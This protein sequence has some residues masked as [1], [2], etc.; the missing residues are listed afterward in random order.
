MTMQG[1]AEVSKTVS[2][3]TLNK[4]R[5]TH[6][7]RLLEGL[8]RGDRVKECVVVEMGGDK[9]AL[10]ET[11]FPARRVDL[12]HPGLPLAAAR[13]AGRRAAT[14]ELLVFLDVDC[15]PS[16]DLVN[17]L[18]EGAASRESLVCCAVT[19]LPDG[20]VRDGWTELDLR[21]VGSRHPAR[22]FPS[23]GLAQAPNPGLF[24]SL[25][26]AVQAKTYDRLDG[27]DEAYSGYGAED[28][29]LAFRADALGI[30]VL[31]SAHGHAYHQRHAAYD[32]P[33]QHFS[34]IISNARRFHDR[35]GVWPMR[36][37]LDAFVRLGLLRSDDSTG[38]T[39]LRVPSADEIALA[40]LPPDRPF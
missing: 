30:P 22:L 32:P 28:T 34:D 13:N 7:V 25:A 3:I 14:G 35:H 26:F 16:A 5:G 33:L 8:S 19:Y 38:Y 39:V 1:S 9:G 36:G 15:I 6:L 11:P 20:A 10:P 37:W 18:A 40:A 12:D 2:V 17:A 4:G 29:D 23:E 27:F 21:R 24:W 31:F